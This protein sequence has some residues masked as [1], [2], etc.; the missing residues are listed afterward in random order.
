MPRVSIVSRTGV[1]AVVSCVITPPASSVSPKRTMRG[2]AARTRS[3]RVA[4]RLVSPLPT[5][6]PAVMAAE[7]SRK[8]VTLCGS[9][10][11]VVASPAE[12]VTTDAFQNGVVAKMLRSAGPFAGLLLS[13]SAAAPISLAPYP[14]TTTSSN[15]MLELM[16][17]IRTRI[18]P[19]GQAP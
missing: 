3:G 19:S 15:R 8:V 17:R 4:T 6:V 10:K 16:P 9:T 13:Y 11:R 5:S 18:D 2:S 14:V 12:S 7:K 1:R